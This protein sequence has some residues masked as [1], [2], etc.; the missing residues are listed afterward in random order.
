MATM[1]IN[2]SYTGSSVDNGEMVLLLPLLLLLGT[3]RVN[4]Q[5][6]QKMSVKVEDE[7]RLVLS[8][9]SVFPLAR[10]GTS[11]RQE[12]TSNATARSASLLLQTPDGQQ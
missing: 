3:E 2:A 6:R 8:P 5:Q 10:L 1:R 4:P 11:S 9:N 12:R 7:A